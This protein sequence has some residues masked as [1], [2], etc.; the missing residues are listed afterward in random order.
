MKATYYHLSLPLSRKSQTQ[1][2]IPMSVYE[3]MNT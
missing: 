1:Y 3:G 2:H